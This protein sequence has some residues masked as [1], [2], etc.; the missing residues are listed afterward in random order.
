MRC[1][2][3]HT[4]GKSSPTVGICQACGAGVCGTHARITLRTVRHGSMLAPP[5]ET[6]ARTIRCPVCTAAQAPTLA[7]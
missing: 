7:T 1:L 5:T 6:K 2:D 3:C 4:A